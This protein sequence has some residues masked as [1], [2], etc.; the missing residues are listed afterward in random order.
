ML[1]D[2]SEVKYGHRHLRE[3]PRETWWPHK[4]WPNRALLAPLR[5]TASH[6]AKLKKRISCREKGFP[7]ETPSDNK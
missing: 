1:V 2:R 4:L 6:C 3:V 5:N 7:Y